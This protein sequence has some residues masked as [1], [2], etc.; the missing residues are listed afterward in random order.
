MEAGT[1]SSNATPSRFP[2]AHVPGTPTEVHPLYGAVAEEVG[3]VPAPGYVL[4]RARVMNA[5][6][7]RPRGSLLEIGCG[8][9]ALL[10][11]LVHMGFRCEAIETASSA[12]RVA[13]HINRHTPDL[14][15]HSGWSH[16]WRERFDYVVALEVLEHIEDDVEA[17]RSWSRWIKP[18]G[19]LVVS[20]PAHAKRWDVDDAAVG[21]YRRYEKR[22]LL[23]LLSS[24]GF[25]VEHVECWG[26]PLANLIRPIRNYKYR[27]KLKQQNGTAHAEEAQRAALSG[28]SGVDR[29]FEARL[30]P[31]QASRLGTTVMS[32]FLELQEAFCGT[33]LGNGFLVVA[34]KLP[35]GG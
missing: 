18:G 2:V 25:A 11:D 21:H 32:L 20:V 14:V 17:L 24:N 29:S 7:N 4:R 13:R 15:L 22:Q 1:Q 16:P 19:T 10:H 12:R 26:Y 34:R 6:Q 3:W 33:E 27:Q 35:D 23:D 8:S 31:L 9:G 5:L 30:Y 28:E